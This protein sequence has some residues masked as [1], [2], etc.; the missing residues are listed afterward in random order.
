MKLTLKT[1]LI[2][3]LAS[4][5]ANSWSDDNIAAC[6]IV[7][8]QPVTSKTELSETE[9]EDAPLIAT[10]I[11]AEEFVYSVFDGK[12]GHLTEVNGHPI[13]ALMC[14]RRYLVPT[15]FDLRLIQTRVPLYLSQDFDSSE[16][17]LM[18]V[19]YKDDEY[20]YQYSGKELNDDNLEILKTRMKYLNTENDK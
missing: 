3:A 20:H 10:F 18:A 13:Q 8:Q 7:V 16:S 11:P 1:L 12:N 9:A 15:E 5:S 19:F 6:E 14:Q 2:G 4:V 17:D